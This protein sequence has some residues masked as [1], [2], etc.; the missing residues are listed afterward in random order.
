MNAFKPKY[1]VYRWKHFYKK[2]WNLNFTSFTTRCGF[3]KVPINF[4]IYLLFFWYHDISVLALLSEIFVIIPEKKQIT[5]TNSLLFSVVLIAILV[6]QIIAKN[7]RGEGRRKLF[8]KVN[9]W[10]I[11]IVLSSAFSFTY[12]LHFQNFQFSRW[13]DFR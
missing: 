9:F 3:L 7:D 13:Y 4:S 2:Q 10:K 11:N 6:Q 8:S 1:A 5:W 12:F